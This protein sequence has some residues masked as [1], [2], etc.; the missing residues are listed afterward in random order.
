MVYVLLIVVSV[1]RLLI[2][3]HF[4]LQPGSKPEKI[5]IEIRLPDQLQADL[6]LHQPV[7]MHLYCY[8]CLLPGWLGLGNS[9]SVEDQQWLFDFMT[10]VEMLLL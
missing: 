1:L 7:L 9:L 2:R 8:H 6:V 10:L 3:L 5:A 4:H